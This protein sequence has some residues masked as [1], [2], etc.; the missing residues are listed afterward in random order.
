MTLLAGLMFL[1][2][3]EPLPHNL[4]N[5]GKMHPIKALP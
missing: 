4:K 2:V 1:P 3:E 5:R